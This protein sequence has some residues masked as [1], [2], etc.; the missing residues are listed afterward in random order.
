MNYAERDPKRTGQ[1]E[2]WESRQA[3][4]KPFSDSHGVQRCP[5]ILHQAAMRNLFCGCRLASESTSE[6]ALAGGDAGDSDKLEKEETTGAC[7]AASGEGTISGLPKEDTSQ[8]PVAKPL[9][10][11]LK[12]P[13][14]EEHVEEC[15]LADCETL[16]TKTTHVEGDLA[17]SPALNGAGLQG[18]ATLSG[19]RPDSNDIP[20]PEAIVP[21]TVEMQQQDQPMHGPTSQG[22]FELAEYAVRFRTTHGW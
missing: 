2:S 12:E 5:Q 16:P 8:Y 19:N 9:L 22:I 21:E 18:T 11:D 1:A 6:P 14:A 3:L 7:A 4:R 10:A 13:E 15:S 20:F 17:E